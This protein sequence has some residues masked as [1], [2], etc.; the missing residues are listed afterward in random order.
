LR[1]WYSWWETRRL[2]PIEVERCSKANLV[3]VTSEREA[4]LLKGH[5]PNQHI[6]VVPNG[7]DITAFQLAPY[8]ERLPRQLIFTGAM[9]YYPNID[10][11][12][13]FARLCWPR[14]R[15][16]A[17]TTTWQIVGRNPPDIVRDLARMGGVSVTGSVPDVRPYLATAT[18]AIAPL[19]IGAGTRLKILEALATGTAVVSTPVGCE[20]LPVVSGRHV[21]LADEPERFAQ[22]IIDLLENASL[23][24]ALGHAGRQLAETYDWP[25]CT[26]EFL[27]ALQTLA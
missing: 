23:R 22:C 11:V 2:K 16:H 6:V 1:K 8:E 12:L 18:L 7:V 24:R 3:L 10:A 21:L 26:D 15:L 19:L 4:S 20:G 5:L 9:D 17:P 25:R 14:I 13:H 27:C